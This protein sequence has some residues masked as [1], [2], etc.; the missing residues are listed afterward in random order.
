MDLF[1]LTNKRHSNWPSA[2]G[3]TGGERDVDRIFPALSLGRSADGRE[4]D[5]EEEKVN[6]FKLIQW[7]RV[8]IG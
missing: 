1:L 6:R 7:R 3:G 5:Q 4:A 8:L 2:G